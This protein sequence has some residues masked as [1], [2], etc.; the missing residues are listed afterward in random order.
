IAVMRAHD[1]QLIVDA[2]PFG[3]GSAGHSHSDTL[4]VVANAGAEEIL[5]DPGTFTYVSDSKARNW[6]RGSAAHNTVRLDKH[7]QAIPAGPFRW[8]RVPGV[9][10]VEWN[11]TADRDYL[12][13][14]C[15]TCDATLRRRVLL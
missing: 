12:H 4:S 1:L 10:I 3:H 2:G 11:S 6:F 14:I 8:I 5:I 15:T 9:K 13:A 7:D